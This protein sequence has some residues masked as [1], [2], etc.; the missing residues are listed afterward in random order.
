M[1]G[2]G[3][4]E[5]VLR[6]LGFGLTLVAAIVV[7][8]DKETKVVPFSI[9]PNLPTFD[10][11]VVAKWHYLSAFV[12][13]F[14]ANVIASLY[15]LLSLAISL[16]NKNRSNILALLITILD[17]VMVVLLSS[18]A[19]AAIAIGIIGYHGNS[20]VRWNKV[21]DTFGR[22]CKQVA[23]ASALSLAGAIVFML[24]VILVVVGLQKRPK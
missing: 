13:L 11:V 21:C 23:A 17:L 24:L 15:G 7:R 22:F 18:S 8:L 2:G 16:A 6:V 20:H 12:Y 3:K 1:S 10:V 9:S 14:A 4:L 5:G 19:G